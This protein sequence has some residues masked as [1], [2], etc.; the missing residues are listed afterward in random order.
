MDR[1]TFAA[2]H[3]RLLRLERDA[4]IAE[5]ERLLR[6]RSDAE[7]QARGTTLLRLEVADLEPGFG[8]RLHVVLRPSRGELPAHR[9]GPGDVVALRA[10]RDEPPLCSGVF[11]RGRGDQLVVAIDDDEVDLPSLVRMDQ[12]ATDVTFRRLDSAL[13]GLQRERKGDEA[14]YLDALFG[15]REATFAA[16]PETAAIAWFDPALDPSQRDA[17]AHALRAEHVA[18]IHGPPGTGKTTAVVELVRQ[19]VARGERV[20]ACAP[21]NVAVDNL[22][23]RLLRAGL[24][25]VRLGHPARVSAAVRDVSLASL[26]ADAPEQKVLRDVKR[27]VDAGLRRV[28]RAKSRQDRWAARNEVR[29]LRAELRQLEA[30]ITKGL[31]DGAEVVLAT[32]VGAASELLAERPFDRVVID[33]AAQALEA[34]CWIPIPLG[35]RV[36]L[37]GD[38][39]QLPPTIQSEQ[40]AAGGLACT[41]FE[42]LMESAQGPAIGRMLTLQYRMHERIQGWSAQRLYDGRLTAAPAVRSHLLTDLP[43]VTANDWT[44]EPLCFVDTAGCSHDESAGDDDG[45]KSN[46]GEAELVVRIVTAL[47]DAGV[48][49]SAIAVITPYNAQ[50]QLLRARLGGEPDLEIGTVDGLQGR[51][52]EAVVVSLVRSNEHG[53]V[54]FL[55]ELRRLNVALTRARRHL[56]VVGDSATLAH[57]KDLCQLVEHLQQHARYRSAFELGNA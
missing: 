8:G 3:L 10:S 47:R 48:P 38:H 1:H 49:G 17:V 29:A 42:R 25:V 34:A 9:F 21:S 24:R 22:A 11:V 5:A 31:V 51:E 27:E 33:E 15:E 7:L 18:L 56:T 46:A 19:C 12:L 4:E 54:G 13:R 35:R 6:V 14:K 52:K 44:T 39:R 37:A 26:V 28:H 30:A 36:V 55:A 57:H 53:E 32:N 43:E 2:E 40:A 50:V 20:L 16:R 41:L 45:S 23:E